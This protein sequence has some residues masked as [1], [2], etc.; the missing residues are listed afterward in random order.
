[1]EIRPLDDPHADAARAIYNHWVEHSTA[2]FAEEPVDAAT[3]AAES[4][5][6]D[7]PRHGSWVLVEGDA[8]ADQV[9]GYVL[10]APYKSRCAYRETAEVSVYL[11][12]DR[13]RA[14]LGTRALAF[15]VDTASDR[16][17]HTLLAT[18]CAENTGSRALFA[19]HGFGE[20]GRLPEV[21]LK[22]GRRLDVVLM[23]RRVESAP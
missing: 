11:H 4:R 8:D 16:G 15:A 14:G 13:L 18:I 17:L 5:F 6:P 23:A 19:R 10:L 21:G 3:F 20:V 2:T 12:P 7:S 1:V 22:F 9:A